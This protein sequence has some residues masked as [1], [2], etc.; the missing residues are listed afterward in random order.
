MTMENIVTLAASV[1]FM[2][3]FLFGGKLHK[4]AWIRHHHRKALSFGAGI[5]VAYVFIHLLPELAAAREVFTEI[6][7][8][9]SLPFPEYRVY[10]SAMMG[11]I[12]FYGIDHMVAWSRK[13]RVKSAP[14]E[15]NG[16]TIFWLHI[17]GFAV[18]VW[19]VSYLMV[20]SIEEETVPIALYAVAMG[21]HFL[22]LEHSLRHEHASTFDRAG[23]YVLAIAPLAGWIMGTLMDLPKS[24][25]ITLL[26][27]ISGAI[28]MNTLIMELPREKEGK[29]W[30][31]LVGGILYAAILLP[32]G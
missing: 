32:L 29:F 19:L 17:G 4:P 9:L 7:E 20:C 22:L 10:L 31:F 1:L 13:T 18:Y 16:D 21:F 3:I 15:R 25:V 30:P 14:T 27:F 2:A 23:R 26:G 8:H 28:I 11:F 6:T 24:M 12:I 5:S